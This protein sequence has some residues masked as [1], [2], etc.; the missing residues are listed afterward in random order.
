MSL[1]EAETATRHLALGSVRHVLGSIRLGKV[2]KCREQLTWTLRRFL[3]LGEQAQ[4]KSYTYVE[5]I[6]RAGA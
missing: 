2:C 1:C 6:R 5:C 3:W 4:T